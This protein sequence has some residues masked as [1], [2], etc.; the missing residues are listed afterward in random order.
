MGSLERVPAATTA[1]I[2][3]LGTTRVRKERLSG[4]LKGV[5][6]RAQRG[7]GASGRVRGRGC[8]PGVWA[9]LRWAACTRLALFWAFLTCTVL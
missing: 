3:S 9:L 7:P 4:V 1:D 6:R 8:E 5:R 2:L